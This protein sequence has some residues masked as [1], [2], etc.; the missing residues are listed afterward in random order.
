MYCQLQKNGFSVCFFHSNCVDKRTSRQTDQAVSRGLC[1]SKKNTSKGIGAPN[2]RLLPPSWAEK[3]IFLPLRKPME[4]SSGLVK[5]QSALDQ[6]KL[7]HSPQTA[8]STELW[9]YKMENFLLAYILCMADNVSQK[10]VSD[11]RALQSWMFCVFPC[12]KIK[13]CA[14]TIGVI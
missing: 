11:S 13:P 3:K 10:N 5:L 2:P 9:Q 4:W 14:N 8:G 6:P 7:V 1:C 12:R